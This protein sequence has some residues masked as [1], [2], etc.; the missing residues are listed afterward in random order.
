MAYEL[1]EK[2]FSNF[3]YKII[4]NKKQPLLLSGKYL[5]IPPELDNKLKSVITDEKEY[6]AIK[7]ELIKSPL[8]MPSEFFKSYTEMK[9]ELKQIS[10]EDQKYLD[11][12]SNADK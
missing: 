12:K 1:I 6:E 9:E 8:S 4:K 11:E 3:P 10:G 2:Y 5:R 7:A